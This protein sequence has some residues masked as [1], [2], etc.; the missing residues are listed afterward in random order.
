MNLQSLFILKECL[1]NVAFAGTETLDDDLAVRNAVEVFA[2]HTEEAPIFAHICAEAQAMLA[3]G[4]DDRPGRLLDVLT[5]VNAA[6]RAYSEADVPGEPAA[7]EPGVGCCVDAPYSR[8]RPVIDALRGSGN[9]RLSILEEMWDAHSAYFGDYRVLPYLAGALGDVNEELEE[10]LAIILTSLGKRAVPELKAGFKPDGK[11]EMSRRVYWIARLAG[12][13]ENEWL[14]SVLPESRREVRESVIAALGVAQENAALLIELYRNESGKCRDAALRALSHMED[15]ESRALWSAELET[16]P[17]CPPCL[18]G[19]DSPLAADMAAQAIRDVFT[20]A[21]ERGR[22]ELNQAELLTLA[23]AIYA[24]YG[25]YSA[26]MRETW[27]WCAERMDALD[28]LRA[29]RTVRQ[30]DLSAAEMLEKCLLETVLWNPCEGVRALAE[31]LAQRLPGCF[32]G[33]A[34]LTDL[35]ARPGEAFARY[36]KYIV[37]NGLL[38]RESAA[39]RANRVQIMRALAAVRWDKNDGRHIPFS[40]KDALTGAPAG[41][42]YHLPE[43][44]PRWAET[45]ENPKVNDDGAVFDLQNPWSMSKQ[46]FRMEWI[47]PPEPEVPSEPAEK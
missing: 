34:V 22:N 32:L 30:W 40:R 31:E 6:E 44:D 41:R 23:H 9:A 33:A 10:L 38:R 39:E 7:P 8:L 1:E 35:L 21:L 18:E 4:N 2:R 43:F 19:V 16:R 47:A 29:D 25:K 27:L 15:E 14:L 46:L 5:L 37:R 26:E 36:N 28:A 12:A 13:E 45:L 20:E 17:D 3:A 11:R 42:V 24:A